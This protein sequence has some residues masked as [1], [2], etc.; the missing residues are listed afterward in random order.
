MLGVE[1]RVGIG[2]SG[3]NRKRET[4]E[5]RE[6]KIKWCRPFLSSFSERV[7]KMTG[8]FFSRHS[9][10][11]SIWFVLFLF[12]GMGCKMDDTGWGDEMLS[13]METAVRSRR[14]SEERKNAVNQ[15]AQKYFRP[16]MPRT[17]AFKLLEDLGSRG[18][19]IGEYRYE[20]ARLWP[21]GELKPYLDEAIKRNFQ[22]QI[23][24]GASKF[25]ARNDRYGRERFIII[26]GAAIGFVLKDGENGIKDVRA[27]I[28]L[29]TI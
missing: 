15:V 2:S 13:E 25:S 5:T 10:F 14:N 29:N 19:R 8:T 21:D 27:N 6:G 18:F 26:K 22:R 9:R 3:C 16:G 11:S 4:Y 24:P 28:W 23:P 7:S 1:P 12:L 20:G 17:E